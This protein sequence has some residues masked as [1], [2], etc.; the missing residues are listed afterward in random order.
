M[1]THC[2]VQ[3]AVTLISAGVAQPNLGGAARTHLH[4]HRANAAPPSRRL[5]LSLSPSGRF[6]DAKGK[7]FAEKLYGSTTCRDSR[8]FSKPKTS[9]TQFIIDHYAGP[10]K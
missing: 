8:R 9:L 4:T 1:R 2:I 3:E 10:V 5:S 6:V 7:D